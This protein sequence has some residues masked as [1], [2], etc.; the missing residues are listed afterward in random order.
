MSAPKPDYSPDAMRS[1]VP[2]ALTLIAAGA[3]VMALLVADAMIGRSA[4]PRAKPAGMRH[5]M[6]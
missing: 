6:P 3:S 1:P 5:H 2:L 4:D